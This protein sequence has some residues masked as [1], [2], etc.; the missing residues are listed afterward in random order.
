MAPRGIT[1]CL[2]K[3]TISSVWAGRWADQAS[4][5]A[6]ATAMTDC[7][8]YFQREAR[9]LGFFSTTLRQSSTQPMAPKP[10]R[11]RRQIQT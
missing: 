5:A 4:Q 7:Q 1:I 8:K 11:V 9:P 6:M 2:K 10:T 3:G